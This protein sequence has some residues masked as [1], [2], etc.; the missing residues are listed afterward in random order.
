MCALHLF[1]AKVAEYM[2]DCLGITDGEVTSTITRE[3]WDGTP[4]EGSETIEV[5]SKGKK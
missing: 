5:I 2:R 4:F 3:L 1:D